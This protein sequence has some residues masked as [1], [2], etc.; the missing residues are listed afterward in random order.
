M[1]AFSTRLAARVV[2]IVFIV[3]VP[4]L[5]IIVYDQSNDRRQAREGAMENANRIAQLAAS[6]QARNLGG[7]QRL[8]TTIA[9]FPQLRAQEPAACRSFLHKVVRD[10]P[11]LINVFVVNADGSQF[12]AAT[13]LPT[14]H[15]AQQSTWFT[16]VMRT[17]SMAIGDYQVSL[18]NGRPAVVFGQPLFDDAGRIVRVVAGVI[19]LEESNTVFKTV[20]LPRG[21][22]LTLTDRHGTILARVPDAAASIGRRHAHLPSGTSS[23]SDAGHKMLESTGSDGV[24]RLYKVVPVE[25]AVSTGLYVALDIESAAVFAAADH[26][27]VAHA[28]L[29]GVLMLG[30]FAVAVIGGRLL[31]LQPMEARQ[32]EAEERMKFALD[33]SKVGVWQTEV[34]PGGDQRVYWSEVLE[35]MHGLAPGGFGGGLQDFFNCMHPDDREPVIGRI[36]LAQ[37]ERRDVEVE[38]RTVLPDGTERRLSTTGHYTFN[39]NGDFIR[40]AG[41]TIDIT[42]QRSLEEQLRHSQKMEAVG[43]LAGGVAHDFN[44]MLTA[45]LGN[46]QFLADDLP[47][48]DRRRADV[49]EI[50]KAA[51]RAAALTQQLLVFSRKQ[52]L[53]P[54]VLRLG[55]IVAQMTPMLRRL[56]GET[57]DLR[58]TMGDRFD[59]KADAGQIGQVVMNLAVNAR[60]AMKRGGRLTIE[61]SDVAIGHVYARQHPEIVAGDYVVM[62]VA[63]TGHGMDAATQRRIF[64]P[65]FTTKATGE[66]T[67]LGLATVYGIVHQ[68]GG[69]VVVTSEPGSGTTFKVYLPRTAEKPEAEALAPKRLAPRGTESVLVVEDEPLVREFAAKVLERQG[70]GVHA[71]A[72]PEQAI[73]YLATGR[74]GID[75]ILTDIVLPGMS[76]QAMA[77]ELRRR[78]ICPV[79]L[80]MSGYTDDALVRDGALDDG[81]LFLHKPFT[82]DSLANAVRQAL[83]ALAACA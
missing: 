58:T 82:S 47:D 50:T 40:G 48:T 55:D 22:T 65:F 83:D 76:G 6:E 1:R 20:T 56:L 33:V 26:L 69:H 78:G 23:D 79:V 32:R 14:S 15:S 17:R 57:V 28:W 44:N 2:L 64:E 77:T 49:D 16:R 4:A 67:G 18:M 30:A 70:Y 29:L 24:K 21:A 74:R 35:R 66:G 73:D 36:V 63:D 75:L 43:K 45:I 27:F 39:A 8:L 5:G 81:T 10:R 7:V 62:T 80:Y 52:I 53:A 12:C 37:A 51:H 31:V 9:L 25:G 68:S 71:V 38:Y 46:A 42:D 11:A 59:V 61:T 34:M 41:V 13:D 19:D 3:I 60:D 54:K 72:S